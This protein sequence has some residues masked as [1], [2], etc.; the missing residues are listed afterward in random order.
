MREQIGGYMYMYAPKTEFPLTAGE[1]A[2]LGRYSDPAI[3]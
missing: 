2:I 1:I 3:G